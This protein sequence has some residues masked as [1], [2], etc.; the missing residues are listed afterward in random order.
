MTV[1]SPADIESDYSAPAVFTFPTVTVDPSVC[2]PL[3]TYSCIVASTPA[4]YTLGQDLCQDFTLNN[5]PFF[6]DN[7]FFEN[8]GDY[9]FDSDDKD[10]FPVGTYGFIITVTIGSESVPIAFDMFLHE[11]CEE[12]ELSVA[13]NPFVGPFSYTLTET[14]IV[15]ITYNVDN[16]VASNVTV[17]CG[18]P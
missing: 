16:L 5:A 15:D 4:A 13:F 6:T 9:V 3:A 10:S 12:A 17:N 11:P 8:D 1:G 7:E 14:G 2:L 18:D